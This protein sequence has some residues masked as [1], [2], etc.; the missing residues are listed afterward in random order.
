M[1]RGLL[2]ANAL[3]LGVKLQILLERGVEG[4]G[5]GRARVGREGVSECC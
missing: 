2:F 3:F 4:K 5:E 1:K